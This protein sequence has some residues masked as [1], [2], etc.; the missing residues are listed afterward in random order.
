[1]VETYFFTYNTYYMGAWRDAFIGA[2]TGR[3]PSRSD[4]DNPYTTGTNSRLSVTNKDLRGINASSISGLRGGVNYSTDEKTDAV[5]EA[6][7]K[8]RRGNT[9]A[10]EKSLNKELGKLV[11]KGIIHKSTKDDLLKRFK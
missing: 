3:K 5:H 6:L 10:S 2:L 4:S 11:N 1:M 9:Y 8:A 7:N